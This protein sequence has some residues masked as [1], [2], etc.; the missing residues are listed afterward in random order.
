MKTNIPKGHLTVVEACKE[1]NV[2]KA[3][4]YSWVHAGHVAAV[5]LGPRRVFVSR[6][7]VRK[8]TTPTAVAAA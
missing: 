2:K 7:D 8:M 4:L 3:T 6:D 1:F 5:R